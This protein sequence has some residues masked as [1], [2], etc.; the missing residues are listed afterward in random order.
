[1]SSREDEVGVWF[2]PSRSLHR[3]VSPTIGV[4]HVLTFSL[5]LCPKI[6]AGLLTSALKN[7]WKF[8]MTHLKTVC[9]EGILILFGYLPNFALI[10]YEI[11]LLLEHVGSA[12][13]FLPSEEV[14]GPDLVC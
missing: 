6:V 5:T 11:K 3:G 12:A 10:K 2:C 9:R 7:Q 1:M 14:V 8:C 4:R 13:E